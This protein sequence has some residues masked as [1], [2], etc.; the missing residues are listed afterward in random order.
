MAS[1]TNKNS[2][3]LVDDNYGNFHSVQ[4]QPENDINYWH[5]SIFACAT[6]VRNKWIEILLC[7]VSKDIIPIFPSSWNLP[8]TNNISSLFDDNYGIF[9]SVHQPENYINYWHFSWYFCEFQIKN[10]WIESL[11]C[12]VSKD[13]IPFFSSLCAA[14]WVEERS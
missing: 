3:F 4:H 13:I 9:H 10:K 5:L 12:V 1:A 14:L 6:D 8:P 2:S 7:L 11:L